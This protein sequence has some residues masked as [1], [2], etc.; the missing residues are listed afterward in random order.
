M[1]RAILQDNPSLV[2]IPIVISR[3]G[4]RVWEE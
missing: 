3:Q 2:P 4:L 1:A